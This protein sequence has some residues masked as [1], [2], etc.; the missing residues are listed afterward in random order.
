M[1]HA[2]VFDDMLD[3]AHWLWDGAPTPGTQIPDG[4]GGTQP[5]ALIGKKIFS[6]EYSVA[7]LNM[8]T[9]KRK[10]SRIGRM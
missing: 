10:P 8:I 7:I 3:S 4:S 1:C 2:G 6:G 9:T 5:V